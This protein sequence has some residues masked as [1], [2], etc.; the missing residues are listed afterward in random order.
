[1]KRHAL[2]IYIHYEHHE[3][4]MKSLGS[5]Y[6]LIQWSSLFSHEKY[7]YMKYVFSSK[8]NLVILRYD[9]QDDGMNYDL[10]A[11]ELNFTT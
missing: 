11:L 1:M 5:H 4:F 2:L 9:E 7:A 6:D 8:E 3:P 10:W